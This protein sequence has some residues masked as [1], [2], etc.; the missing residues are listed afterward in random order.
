MVM[1]RDV[2]EQSST[3]LSGRKLIPSTVYCIDSESTVDVGRTVYP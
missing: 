3:L 1:L 2:F